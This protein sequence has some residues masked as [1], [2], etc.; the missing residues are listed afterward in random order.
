MQVD[1]LWVSTVVGQELELALAP[2]LALLTVPKWVTQPRVQKW[3]QGRKQI[4]QHLLQ[5]RPLGI[6]TL[7]P[8]QGHE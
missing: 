6:L 8:A 2:V 7:S 3:V 4:L 1:W 5:V